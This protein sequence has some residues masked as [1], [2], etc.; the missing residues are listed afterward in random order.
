MIIRE[1]PNPTDILPTSTF[2][3]I[4]KICSLTNNFKLLSEL[5]YLFAEKSVNRN[6][7]QAII[8]A[9]KSLQIMSKHLELTNS[10]AETLSKKHSA[11]IQF[12]LVKAITCDLS[13]R[14][15][16]YVK[17]MGR[18]AAQNELERTTEL[19]NENIGENENL[20]AWV[21]LG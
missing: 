20:E 10:L 4:V 8:L 11:E 9:S 16:D 18:Q 21:T 7:K 3:D 15:Q 2:Q 13:L 14:V 17:E 6:P 1:Q 19:Y 5:Y 12:L